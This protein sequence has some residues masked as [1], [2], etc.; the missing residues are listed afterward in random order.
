MHFFPRC[1]LILLGC[2]T[3]LP[4][5][6]AEPETDVSPEL[7]AKL[8]AMQE[9]M[10]LLTGR[11]PKTVEKAF[12]TMTMPNFV[13]CVDGTLLDK[14]KVLAVT[15]KEVLIAKSTSIHD[16]RYTRSGNTLVCYALIDRVQVVDGR[17]VTI[18]NAPFQDVFVK[19]GDGW[20]LLFSNLS[21]PLPAKK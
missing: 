17:E 8:S 21:P 12:V 14:E 18:N 2:G 13:W 5:F 1:V 20:K 19:T 15:R 16:R 3:A 6:A 4:G 11:D 7:Q 9:A 10:T